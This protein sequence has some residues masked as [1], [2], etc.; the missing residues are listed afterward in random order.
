MSEE[1]WVMVLGLVGKDRVLLE[2][3]WK[4]VDI[5]V[6]DCLQT[7][8]LPCLMLCSLCDQGLFTP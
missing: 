2:R 7:N 4:C 1:V 8:Y 5:P 3:K 6:E